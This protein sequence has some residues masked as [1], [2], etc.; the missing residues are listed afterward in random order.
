MIKVLIALKWLKMVKQ[1]IPFIYYFVGINS[2]HTFNGEFHLQT[3]YDGK[4]INRLV[5]IN[6]SAKHSNTGSITDTILSLHESS[7]RLLATLPYPLL[8]ELRTKAPNEFLFGTTEDDSK[9]YTKQSILE[10]KHILYD[11]KLPMNLIKNLNQ[12]IRAEDDNLKSFVGLVKTCE[13]YFKKR[14][15]NYHLAQQLGMVSTLL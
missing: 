2:I 11:Y 4:L 5:K 12:F 9:W 1:V 7:H 14:K 8:K 15:N 6:S 10:F 13:L 3:T